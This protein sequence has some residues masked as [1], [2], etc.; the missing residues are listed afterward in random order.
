MGSSILVSL[1]LPA[2]QLFSCQLC[3]EGASSWGLQLTEGA[4][5]LQG[6]S[7]VVGSGEKVGIVGRTGSGKSSLIVA[8]FRLAEPHQGAIALD[9][10]NLL[11]MGLQAR[12]WP[13]HCPLTPCP[14]RTLSARSCAGRARA[15]RGHPAGAHPVQR[16]HPQQRGPLRPARGPRDMD[17]AR[18]RRPQGAD[19]STKPRQ[20][21]MTCCKVITGTP[22][23]KEAGT[24]SALQC[25]RSCQA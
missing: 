15:H 19:T 25:D 9:G 23:E 6:V 24:L 11:D 4:G 21:A 12:P 18:A 16:D 1:L 5:H 10:F 2:I 20:H 8:L 14:G 17:R 13:A 22:Y 3:R 7:F